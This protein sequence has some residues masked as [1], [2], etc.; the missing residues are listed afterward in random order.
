MWVQIYGRSKLAKCFTQMIFSRPAFA[1][2]VTQFASDSSWG[3]CVRM[4]LYINLLV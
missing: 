1:P 4:R 3:I 2:G